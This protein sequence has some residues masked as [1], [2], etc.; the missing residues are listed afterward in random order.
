[1]TTEEETPLYAAP[2]KTIQVGMTWNTDDPFL[3]AIGVDLITR[4][5]I[6][7][8]QGWTGGITGNIPVT[9]STF[10]NYVDTYVS[11]NNPEGLAIRGNTVYICVDFADAS[12]RSERRVDSSGY[13]HYIPHRETRYDG[14]VDLQ[15]RHSPTPVN[16]IPFLREWKPFV[17]RAAHEFDWTMSAHSMQHLT[18]N[19]K[20]TVESQMYGLIAA[21]WQIIDLLENASDTEIDS[22]TSDYL[23]KSYQT[24]AEDVLVGLCHECEDLSTFARRFAH[25]A[26]LELFRGALVSGKV[27]QSDRDVSP[28]GLG[29]VMTE[30]LAPVGQTPSAESITGFHA[31]NKV[32]YLKA[33]KY[34]DIEVGSAERP[35]SHD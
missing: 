4:K 18:T 27:H 21:P 2:G 23:W 17:A 1:M 25:E 11:L 6:S 31:D 35:H 3:H 9:Q 20:W 19:Q 12:W 7:G 29:T 24:D 5:I 16:Q 28:W 32:E 26:N 33:L 34:Y 15:G 13:V 10:T 14:Y 30:Q 8:T 22:F